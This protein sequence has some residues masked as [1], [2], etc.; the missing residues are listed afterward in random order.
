MFNSW[1]GMMEKCYEYFEGNQ[2]D[3]IMREL[4]GDKFC[5]EVEGTLC[6]DHDRE[7]LEEITDCTKEEACDSSCCTYYKEFKNRE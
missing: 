6:V 4:V 5:W 1:R 3:C 7:Y 2:Q